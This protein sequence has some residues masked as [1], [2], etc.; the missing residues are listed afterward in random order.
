MD[1]GHKYA[2]LDATGTVNITSGP[3]VLHTVVCN[4]PGGPTVTLYDGENGT[5][6]VIAALGASVVGTFL[7]DL[8]FT[9]GLSAVVAGPGGLD[10]TITYS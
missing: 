6:P 9:G 4:E 2:H 3:G 10:V 1:K 8:A 7:Y 5:G